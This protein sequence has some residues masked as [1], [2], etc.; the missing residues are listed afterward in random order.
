MRKYTFFSDP[1]HGWLR[2]PISDLVKY[3]VAGKITS[4]SYLSPS[5]KWAYLEEDLD[6][7]T[8]L[9]AVAETYNVL[10]RELNPFIK[11]KNCAHNSSRIRTYPSY[12]VQEVQDS[13]IQDAI[14][15]LKQK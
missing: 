7:S 3:N 9:V 15:I 13:L 10:V 14:N 4:Y 2:V 1:S 12:S 5:K 11:E 8:F 6:A